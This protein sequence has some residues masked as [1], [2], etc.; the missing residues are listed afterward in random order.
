MDDRLEKRV[1]GLERTQDIRTAVEA[2]M[3]GVS[4]E[5]R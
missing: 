1:S 3:D 4:R 5:I 2:A